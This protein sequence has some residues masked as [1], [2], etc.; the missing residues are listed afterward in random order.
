MIIFQDYCT[1]SYIINVK[2]STSKKNNNFR[3]NDYTPDNNVPCCVVQFNFNIRI[4]QDLFLK[5]KL[6]DK[7]EVFGCR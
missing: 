5:C 6:F 2:G 7:S 4:N 1:L 3:E